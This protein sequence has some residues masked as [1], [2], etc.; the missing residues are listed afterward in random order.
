MGIIS[1]VIADT[2]FLF[3]ALEE[4]YYPGHPIDILFVF[5][6]LFFAFGVY[7]HIKLYRNPSK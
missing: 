3:L 6:Y 4:S 2:L 5:A 1:D 7:S